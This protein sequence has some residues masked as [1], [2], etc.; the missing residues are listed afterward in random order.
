MRVLILA[1]AATVALASAALSQTFQF[2]AK[3]GPDGKVELVPKSSI[4][5]TPS[6]EEKGGEEA[7]KIY[8]WTSDIGTVKGIYTSQSAV[9]AQKLDAGD[10]IKTLAATPQAGASWGNW[11][12]DYLKEVAKEAT[13]QLLQSARDSACALDPRPDTITPTIEVSF[14]AVAGGSLSVSATWQTSTLCKKL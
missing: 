9:L 8:L 11:T 13:R 6:V 4:D 14:S 2:D 3:I 7:G 10:T 1:A 5:L 12:S